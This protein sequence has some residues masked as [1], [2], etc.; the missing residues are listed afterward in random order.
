[1][2]AKFVVVVIVAYVLGSIPFG[3]IIGKLK[4][5][6]DIRKHGSG[7]TGAT[8]VMRTVG[9]K[10][11]VLTIALD[12]GKAVGA[13]ML[14]KAIIGPGI[15]AI[16]GINLHWQ[17]AQVMAGLAVIAGHNWSIFVKFKGGRGAAAF[18]GTMFALCPPVALFGTE[19]WALAAMRSRYMSMGSILG[20]L[21][22]W[23][24]MVPLTIAYNFPPIYLVYG[25]IAAG[26][27]V[28]QHRDN[29]RRLQLGIE[30]RLGEK[31]RRS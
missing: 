8:N 14:A 1:M 6:V 3:L 11:G 7:K 22:T 19:V 18:F 24:L 26:L 13:V 2:I 25:L 29:I 12:L 21:A 15:L 20:V 5:N 27:V 16:G 28:Y 30:R 10:A 9:T 17:A 31:E 23:C 4:G